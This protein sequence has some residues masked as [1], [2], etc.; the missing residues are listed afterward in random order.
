M[1][2][3]TCPN[4]IGCTAKPP[5]KLR[6][7]W[8]ITS[9]RKPWLWF[10]MHNLIKLMAQLITQ[11]GI[12]NMMGLCGIKLSFCEDLFL[13]LQ[14]YRVITVKKNVIKLNWCHPS[15]EK[16][17][18]FQRVFFSSIY[19]KILR[20]AWMQWIFFMFFKPPSLEKLPTPSGWHGDI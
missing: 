5:L 20:H 6:Y 7:V 19:S 18:I 4:S 16:H 15:N 13:H 8:L 2:T 9:H 11:M 17:I 3:Q 1:I 10:I 14:P 12:E